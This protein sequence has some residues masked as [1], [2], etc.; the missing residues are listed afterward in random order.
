MIQILPG[1]NVEMVEPKVDHDLLQLTPTEYGPQDPC[2]CGLLDDSLCTL[3][4]RLLELGRQAKPTDGGQWSVEPPEL[5]R[6]ITKSLQRSDAP[7]QF[8]RF[9]DR[10]GIELLGNVAVNPDRPN[11]MEIFQR[12]PEGEPVQHMDDSAIRYRSGTG[13][14]QH[15][16]TNQ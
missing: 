3:T 4:L 6:V 11:M 12:R 15:R 9:G 2:L 16:H 10:F 1:K 8:E 13:D 7:L 14:G 5:G